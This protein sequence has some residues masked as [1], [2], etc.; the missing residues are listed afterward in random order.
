[1]LELVW[2]VLPSALPGSRALPGANS[3]LL[4][5]QERCRGSEWNTQYA[6]SERCKT[7]K[8][9]PRPRRRQLDGKAA[10]VTLEIKEPQTAPFTRWRCLRPHGSKPTSF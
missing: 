10:H 4:G 7:L 9:K 8:G 5:W 3:A 1:M 2:P 6:S